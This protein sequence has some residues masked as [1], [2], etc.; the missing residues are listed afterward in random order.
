MSIGASLVHTQ[1]SVNQF[2]CVQSNVV[3]P[4]LVQCVQHTEML[5]WFCVSQLRPPQPAVYLFVLDV[6]HNAMEAGY[7]QHFCDSLLDNLDK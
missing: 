5:I 7:L 2:L 3:N 1:C 6:S 4:N